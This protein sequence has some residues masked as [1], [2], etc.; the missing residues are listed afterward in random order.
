[1]KTPIKSLLAL[2][3]VLLAASVLLRT[4]AQIHND[5]NQ[6][7]GE[8]EEAVKMPSRVSVIDGQTVITVRTATQ[9]HMGIAVAPLK[10]ANTRREESAAATVLATQGLVT[11]RNSYVAAEAQLEKSQ[12]QFAVS[13][14]EYERLL[15][16]YK[17][18]QNASQKALQAAQ[19]VMQTDRA[20][21][22][23]A[24]RGLQIASS[25]VR[26]TWGGV[27]AAWVVNN[28]PEL[29]SVLNQKA[30]LIQVSLPP[31]TP[32]EHPLEIRLSTPNGNSV[33]AHYVSPFP[34]VDP[35]IQS[36]SELYLGHAYPI[37]EPG[38][39]LITHLPVGQRLR[40]VLIPHSAIVWW[41]GQPWV[42][43]QTAP[44]R[45]ARRAVPMDQ[46]LDEGY[47]ANEGFLRGAKVVTRGAEVLLSE[48]F[49]S[50]IQPED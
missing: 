47:V 26:Q 36:I 41:Q 7:E 25:A 5:P 18:N 13:Q 1:M 32:F 19:G 16:L 24:E 48:E 31:E 3:F 4:Y 40:G 2:G 14:R 20:D 11:L 42:Y 46:P 27:V 22:D 15:S 12:A 28:S 45:F 23:A 37:L 50:Q 39:Y 10:P 44:T 30:M 33:S 6:D 8:E 43:E 38:M 29:T 9:E 34:Q 35:R 49:R 21:L 17:E